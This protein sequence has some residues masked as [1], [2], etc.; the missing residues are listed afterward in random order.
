MARA[1]GDIAA[2]NLIHRSGVEGWM[3]PLAVRTGHQGSGVGKTPSPCGRGTYTTPGKRALHGAS[4]PIIEGMYV[5]HRDPRHNPL[6]TESK[7]AGTIPMG[8][9]RC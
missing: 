2:F 4:L 3:G 8:A 5:R 6:A 9:Q 1:R 7:S